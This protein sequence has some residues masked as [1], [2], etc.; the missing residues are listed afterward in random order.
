MT[1]QGTAIILAEENGARALANYPHARKCGEFIYVSGVSSRRTDG[2]WEG[3][4]VSADGKVSLDIEKQTA[5]V[6]RNINKILVQ[7]GSSIHNAFDAT[8]FLTDMDHYSGMNS[9][10]NK[11]FPNAENAPARTCVAVKQ[12]P[13]PNLLVEI[14]VVA[15]A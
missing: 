3:V 2:T 5:A 13:N 4:E 9:E 10:W 12:L 7:A 8:V 15:Y 14:K 11:V 1:R 6:L